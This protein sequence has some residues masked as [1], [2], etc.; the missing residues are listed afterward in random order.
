MRLWSVLLLLVTTAATWLLIGEL[1]DRRRSLQLAGAAVVGMQPMAVFVSSSVNPDA[2]LMACFALAFWLGA[3]VLR[4]GLT[5]RD[6]LALGAVTALAIVTKGT[7]YA[8]VPAVA[9]AVGVGAWRLLPDRRAAILAAGLSG[10][11][12]A[13]PVGFWLGLARALDRAA[14]NKVPGTGGGAGGAAGL[15]HFGFLDYLWQF[16]LPK[17]P[18]MA[19]PPFVGWTVRDVYV[20]RLYGTFGQ[21]EITVTPGVTDAVALAG[22]ALGAGAVVAVVVHRRALLRLWPAVSVLVAGTVGTLLLV[23]L[24]AFHDLR[25]DPSDPVI[26]GRY[27]LP[28]LPVLGIGVAG[29]LRALPRRAFAAAGGLTMATCVLLQLGA[30]GATITR[31]YA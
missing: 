11:A 22:L 24:Q 19:P 13:L 15:P 10:A 21:L 9:L 14:V 30:L 6:G 7:G 16:Y 23:H 2:A 27:L 31:F 18:G 29:V 25:N 20:D 8:L 4:R 17:L 12:L 28:L 5:V 3:R 1:T 26:T